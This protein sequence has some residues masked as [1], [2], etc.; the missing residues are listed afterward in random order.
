MDKIFVSANDLLVDTFHLALGVEESGY[1]PSFILGI[2]H[3][4]ASISLTIQEYFSYR[5]ADADQLAIRVERQGTNGS[6][7]F[8]AD[9]NTLEYLQ[10]RLSKTDSVL[11]VDDMFASG[12]S[13]QA[14]ITGLSERMGEETPDIQVASIW[15]KPLAN[16]VSI[17]PD[18]YLR[19]T[20]RRV[21]FPH[22]LSDLT[23]EEMRIGKPEVAAMVSPCYEMETPA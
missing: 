3:G 18:V 21:V 11:V 7:R 5:G 9:E 17:E 22:E 8:I 13:A 4:G 16:E 10:T 23:E 1:T 12:Q 20:E 2:W 19:T 14:V 15:Y 6:T